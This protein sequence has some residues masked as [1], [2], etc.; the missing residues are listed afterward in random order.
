MNV[1][2]ASVLTTVE[3][4]ESVV[5][6][7]AIIR[8]ISVRTVVILRNVRLVRRRCRRFYRMENPIHIYD[9]MNVISTGL[10]RK[11]P[12]TAG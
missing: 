1:S 5:N 8:I 4:V 11:T 2:T 10:L 6:P 9:V 7:I 12:L 3:L